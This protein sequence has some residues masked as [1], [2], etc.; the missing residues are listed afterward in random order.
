MHSNI[1]SAAQGSPMSFNLTWPR[2]INF[3][4]VIIIDKKVFFWQ[5]SFNWPVLMKMGKYKKLREDLRKRIVDLHK[6]VK[7][8]SWHHFYKLQ[9]PRLSGQSTLYQ[10][11]FKC[12][13]N[14]PRSERRPKVSPLNESKLVRMFRNN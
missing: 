9:I 7:K 12:F 5:P 10:W 2:P 13:T 1:Q 11:R 8:V 14:L 4:F 3:S 6:L